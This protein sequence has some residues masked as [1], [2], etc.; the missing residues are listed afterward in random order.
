MLEAASKS[1]TLPNLPN[2]SN[3]EEIFQRLFFLFLICG[4]KVKTAPPGCFQK[5]KLKFIGLNIF[6]GPAGDPA[7]L[8]QS[9]YV[10]ASWS[11]RLADKREGLWRC[12]GPVAKCGGMGSICIS[13][14]DP[15]S[16]GFSLHPD[17]LH[18]CLTVY[19]PRLTFTQLHTSITLAGPHAH[20]WHIQT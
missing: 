2:S 10:P 14:W 7:P 5:V 3:S 18:A 13:V 19:C 11:W 17:L 4:Q 9:H 8:G 12:V 1:Q 16:S 6:L 20:T 15:D